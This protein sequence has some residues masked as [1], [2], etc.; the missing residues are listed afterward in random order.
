M[1]NRAGSCLKMKA[2]CKCVTR[3]TRFKW[4]PFCYVVLTTLNAPWCVL[5]ASINYVRTV[6]TNTYI[7]IQ[8]SSSYCCCLYSNSTNFYLIQIIFAICL[9]MG[10]HMSVNANTH[11]VHLPFNNVAYVQTWAQQNKMWPRVWV[12]A[13]FFSFSFFFICSMHAMSTLFD[14]WRRDVVCTEFYG[15]QKWRISNG[16][17]MHY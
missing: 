6:C 11:H 5:C 12:C 4:S 15:Q 17:Y 1:K 2:K 9:Y 8:Q 13:R 3:K 10:T 14:P 7:N 16:N